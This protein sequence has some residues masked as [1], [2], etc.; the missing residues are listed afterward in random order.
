MGWGSFGVGEGG[1]GGGGAGMVCF[2]Q[3]E[4]NRILSVSLQTLQR[5]T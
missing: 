5:E 2:L 3:L 1:V 4:V